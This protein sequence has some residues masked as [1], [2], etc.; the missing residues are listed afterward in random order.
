MAVQPQYAADPVIG[1]NQVS[2]ANT[3]RD[4]T[5]TLASL[6][7][8]RAPGTRIDR[9]KV[10]AVGTTTAGM[11]RIFHRTTGLTLNADGTVASFA[12]PTAR[13]VAELS[14]SAITPSGTVQSF[15]GEI[16]LPA[17]FVMGEFES[18]HA[19]TQN[20]ETFNVFVIGSHL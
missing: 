19:A 4:G 17:D 9:L 2:V 3:N 15:E 12:A 20:A 16:L 5:G 11:I 1:F 10:K 8:G 14:V 13:L 6:V 7:T 18:L